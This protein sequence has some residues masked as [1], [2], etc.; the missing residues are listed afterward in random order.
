MEGK[1][2][3]ERSL[4][5]R[6]KWAKEK[7]VDSNT[8]NT[9]H[10][11]VTLLNYIVIHRVC[12]AWSVCVHIIVP[13]KACKNRELHRNWH[14]FWWCFSSGSEIEGSALCSQ[15]P[16]AQNV[17]KSLTPTANSMHAQRTRINPPPSGE[18]VY[19]KTSDWTHWLS[20][21]VENTT[22]IAVISL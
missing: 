14:A 11:C 4:H 9:M 20:L 21:S 8:E 22:Y 19:F 16:C 6:Q 7:M 13:S 17:I 5:E 1:I 3:G 2:I 18:H 10:A 12:V 15:W